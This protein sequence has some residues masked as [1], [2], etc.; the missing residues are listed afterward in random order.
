M[1][2]VQTKNK[3]LGQELDTNI[4]GNAIPDTVPPSSS[5]FA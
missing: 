1:G 2:L 4:L 3:L 5:N